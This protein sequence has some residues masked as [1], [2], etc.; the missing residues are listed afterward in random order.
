M[1]SLHLSSTM[2]PH[3]GVLEVA[4]FTMIFARLSLA[5]MFQA[6]T[7]GVLWLQGAALPWQAAP[8]WTVYGSLIDGICLAA[9][10]YGYCAPK[11]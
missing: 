9:L 3:S 10:W 7:A 4:P 1:N 5:V 11:G 6:L 8:W 2:T